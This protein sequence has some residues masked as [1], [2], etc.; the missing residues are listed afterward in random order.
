MV[1][2]GIELLLEVGLGKVL[3]GLIKCI[4]DILVV[5][6]VNDVVML[7]SVFEN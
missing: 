2:E 6:L 4:V 5:V 7:I 1:V 3:I